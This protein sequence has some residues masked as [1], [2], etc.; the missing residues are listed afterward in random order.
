M[1]KG[2]VRQ[3]K[4]IIDKAY[5]VMAE[6]KSLASL[7][8]LG[9]LSSSSRSPLVAIFPSH[10]YPNMIFSKLRGNPYTASVI[11]ALTWVP[12]AIF[13]VDHGYSYAKVSGRSM[14]VKRPLLYVCN[15]PPFLMQIKHSLHSTQ[16]PACY[17]KISYY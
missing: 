12:V 13:F 1:S 4:I 8:S 7:G 17:K 10:I 6:V 5:V 9:G 16:I 3:K 15:F 2:K 11:S 14:Q